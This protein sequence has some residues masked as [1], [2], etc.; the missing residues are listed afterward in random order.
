MSGHPTLSTDVVERVLRKRY[1]MRPSP[2]GGGGRHPAWHDA[3]GRKIH[4]NMKQKDMSRGSLHALSQEGESVGLWARREFMQ[5]IRIELGHSPEP[6]PD[7]EEEAATKENNVATKNDVDMVQRL[8]NAKRTQVA[9]PTTVTR[10]SFEIM[11][12]KAWMVRA[13]VNGVQRELGPY[14]SEAS[15]L[16]GLTE[17][18]LEDQ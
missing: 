8:T 6:V 12:T 1:G 18:L 5:W 10:A 3:R 2:T 13:N 4:P 16:E 17:L 14:A 7:S 15:A 11:E 9:P